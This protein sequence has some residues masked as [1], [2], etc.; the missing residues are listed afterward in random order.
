LSNSWANQDY[1]TLVD[2]SFATAVSSGNYI[3]PIPKNTKTTFV[4]R[5]DS[6]N[7]SFF[8]NGSLKMTEPVSRL[9]ANQRAEYITLGGLSSGS[10][11]H[12][13]CSMFKIW[14]SAL[15]D[16]EIPRIN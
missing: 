12:M 11:A 14:D 6:E 5:I 1:T 7:I 3:F 9:P 8:V 2:S 4:F 16:G 10:I 13:E 15:S